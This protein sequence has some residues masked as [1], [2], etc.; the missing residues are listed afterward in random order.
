M[1]A[2][3]TF[4]VTK[5]QLVG[6]QYT[7]NSRDTCIIGRHPDCK[8][9]IPSDKYHSTISRY[10]CLLD[11][12]PPDIRIR[13][14]GSLHGTF[15]NDKCI[16]KRDKNQTPSQGANLE[17]LE[18]DLESGDVIKLSNTT[19]KVSI[20]DPSL[21]TSTYIIPQQINP[22]FPSLV[23]FDRDNDLGS[24]KGYTKIKLLGKGGFGEVYLAR[25]TDKTGTKLVALKLLLP[26]VAVMPQMKERFLS[27]AELTKKL[28]HPNLINF[29]DYGEADGVFFFTMEYCDRGSV[30]DLM[31]KQGGKL[32]VNNAVD[33]ILQVLDGLHYA[34]TEK[35]LV[36]RDI[37][38]ANIFLIVNKGKI[39]AKLGDYGL[40]KAFDL[41]GLSGQTMTGSA[42]GT[43]QFMP[44]QQVL[45]FKYAQ[46]DVDVWAVAATLYFM[47]T[48][49]FPR[50][51]T[52]KINPMLEILTKPPVPIRER[53][54][55]IPKPLANL[56]DKALIDYPELHFKS[57]IAFKQH[58]IEAT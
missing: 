3:V 40:A 47:L 37:K 28:D 42:M 58:L 35:K 8:I 22:N 55:S 12:N 24:I 50:D 23:K 26:R 45:E 56:I 13:D 9:Q 33:I 4:T 18:Y 38:P 32:S 52:D 34:H 46:P 54:A 15:I 16:G 19:F 49:A 20:K 29:D 5:G 11:I 10:H 43:P 31:L 41:A 57:A 53:D 30:T 44:R 7:F 2:E 14:F 6:K 51:L 25:T 27:E 48:G 21:P 36:H 1:S 39:I 17:L